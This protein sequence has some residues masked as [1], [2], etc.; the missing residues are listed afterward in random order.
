MTTEGGY[1]DRS[2]R[3]VRN[4][5][6]S[7]GSR[8][9]RRIVE[10]AGTFD[11]AELKRRFNGAYIANRGYDRA[12]AGAVL[13]EDRADLVSFATPNMANPDLAKCLRLGAPLALPDRATF[14]GGDHRGYTDYP[15][16]ER[17]A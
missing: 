15:P 4:R 3:F 16:L 17:A 9:R 8:R 13:T 7:A 5:L 2:P 1:F 11:W 12:R 6:V 14:Y 10:D